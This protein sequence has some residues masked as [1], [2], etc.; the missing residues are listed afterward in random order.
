MKVSVNQELCQGHTMCGIACPEL[1]QFDQVLGHAQM[2]S[3]NVP[4]ELEPKVRL[5]RDACPEGAIEIDSSP[6]VRTD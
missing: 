4:P 2:K 5:A 3:N 1:F 6:G